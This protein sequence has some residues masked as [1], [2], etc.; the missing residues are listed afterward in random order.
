MEITFYRYFKEFCNHKK[1][2]KCSIL[3]QIFSY[4]FFLLKDIL[5]NT[6]MPIKFLNRFWFEVCL[7]NE[8]FNSIFSV[9]G[10]I[11]IPKS[12]YNYG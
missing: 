1:L 3:Y 7:Y 5:K 10:L 2:K 4:N 9:G 11:G 12:K 8:I 6:D